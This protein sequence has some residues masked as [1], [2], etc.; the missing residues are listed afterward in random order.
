MS[1]NIALAVAKGNYSEID[2]QTIKIWS[3]AKVV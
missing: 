1:V 3:K 2:N